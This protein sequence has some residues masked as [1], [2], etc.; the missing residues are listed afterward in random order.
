M[1]SFICLRSMRAW[2]SRCSAALSPSLYW[3][4]SFRLFFS[5]SHMGSNTPKIGKTLTRPFCLSC[6]I[7]MSWA[8]I[9]ADVIERLLVCFTSPW[10]LTLRLDFLKAVS[11]LGS[12]CHY[13]TTYGL[14]SHHG[15]KPMNCAEELHIH[16]ACLTD[17]LAYLQQKQSV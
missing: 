1:N 5:S 11:R 15:L 10:S 6:G 12:A 14:A 9:F 16:A 13:I 7:G 4:V 2:N 17:H 3:H 8:V